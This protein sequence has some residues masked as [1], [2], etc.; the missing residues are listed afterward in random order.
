ITTLHFVPS[1]LQVFL[2]EDGVEACTSL[3]RVI[4]SGEALS[5]ELQERFFARSAAELHNL[6]G[7]TEAA[8]DV[9]AWACRRDGDPRPVPIG[10][11]IA[12]TQMYVLDRLLQPVP[13]GVAGELCIA[14][15]NLARGYLD[16]PELTGERFVAN[17]FDPAPGARLYRTGD[18][19]R[20]RED[21]AID[22]LG[23]LDHQVKLRG[24][25]IELGEIEQ[26]LSQHPGVREAIVTAR[27]H[28]GDT[29]LVAY[30]SGDAE[31]T[32]GDLIAFLKARL[33]EYM[34]PAAFVFVRAFPLT[35]NG[36][37][38]RAALPEPELVR[39]ELSTPYQAP[40]DRI[41]QA[42]AQIWTQLLGIERIGV[43]D[44]FFEL[45]GHSLLMAELRS[46]LQAALGRPLT[47]VELFQFPTVRSLA[48]HLATAGA[49]SA[50]AMAS[51]G[52]RV[53]SRRELREHRQQ[54]AAARRARG[55]D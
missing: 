43:N 46:A 32:A 34:V 39:P 8:V 18:L 55:K 45:G 50:A 36:K 10:S 44:N 40:R 49:A 20:H 9:T 33:P 25:R 38:D 24:F 13:A 3:R 15:R 31:P 16:R 4:C 5:R 53:E 22:Y 21:G 19:A 6:Y 23:R 27:Q 14:G 12:N 52:H 29:R 11:P 26:V 28:A 51:A 37:V 7:P 2:L 48:E 1:M 54:A 35:P 41:E 42:I 17:P 30:L 47:I